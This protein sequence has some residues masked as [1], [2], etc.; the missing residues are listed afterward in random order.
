MWHCVRLSGAVVW[1]L[2]LENS[3]RLE[4]LSF[5][6]LCKANGQLFR[7]NIGLVLRQNFATLKGL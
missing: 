4:K 7:D 1:R 3:V 5:Q 6:R 2:I